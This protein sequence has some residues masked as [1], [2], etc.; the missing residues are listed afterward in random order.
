MKTGYY[1]GTDSK[2]DIKDCL[3]C[4]LPD[5]LNCKEKRENRE[6]HKIVRH[7]AKVI[8]RKGSISYANNS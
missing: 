1:E 3:N 6:G 2:N 5:C 8:N 7:I 4:Q